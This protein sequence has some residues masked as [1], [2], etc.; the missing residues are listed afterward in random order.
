MKS[1]KRR[2]HAVRIA[3]GLLGIGFL[4]LFLTQRTLHGNSRR[5]SRS[6]STLA[7]RKPIILATGLLD[8]A[9]IRLGN[10]IAHIAADWGINIQVCNS[11]GSKQNLEHSKGVNSVITY[12]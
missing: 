4:A 8:G 12:A 3:L 10:A 1:S 9:Y 5:T 2:S 6:D 7:G 11:Q